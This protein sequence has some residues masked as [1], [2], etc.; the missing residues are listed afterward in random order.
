MDDLLIIRIALDNVHPPE[1]GENARRAL[2]RVLEGE[3]KSTQPSADGRRHEPVRGPT[4]RSEQVTPA[5][6]LRERAT[7]PASGRIH[8]D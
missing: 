1:L 3:V 4:M 2:S 8:L 6:Y 5:S 7:G